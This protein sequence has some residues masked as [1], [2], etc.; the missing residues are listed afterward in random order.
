MAYRIAQLTKNCRNPRARRIAKR[1]ASRKVRRTARD[2]V[3]PTRTLRYAG[4]GD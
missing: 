1:A 2:L 3:T 4:W